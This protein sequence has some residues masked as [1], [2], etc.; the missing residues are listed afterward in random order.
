MCCFVTTELKKE[1]RI[2]WP[3]MTLSYL[4]QEMLHDWSKHLI[5][6]MSILARTIC[7]LSNNC[8]EMSFVAGTFW[9]CTSRCR[10]KP[11]TGQTIFKWHLKLCWLCVVLVTQATCYALLNTS[12]WTSCLHGAALKLRWTCF[13]VQA[14]QN[15]KLCG[16][17]CA[18]GAVHIMFVSL[19]DL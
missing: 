2:C 13:Y 15:K 10:S 17:L 6:T 3:R 19:V 16:W 4:Q 8:G 14:R 9:L 11:T 1:K 12:V 5:K 7:K 18:G